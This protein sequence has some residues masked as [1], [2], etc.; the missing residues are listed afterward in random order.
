M[1][2]Q[3]ADTAVAKKKSCSLKTQKRLFCWS[4]STWKKKKEGYEVNVQIDPR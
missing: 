3:T 2:F 4:S 1:S